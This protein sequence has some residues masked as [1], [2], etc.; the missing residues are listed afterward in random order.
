MASLKLGTSV[1]CSVPSRDSHPPS[2]L[3]EGGTWMVDGFIRP[4]VSVIVHLPCAVAIRKISWTSSFG[5]HKSLLHKIY[6]T[7]STLPCSS[8]CQNWLTW[9]R[10]GISTSKDGGVKFANMRLVKDAPLQTWGKLS[11]SEDRWE[12]K[13]AHLIYLFNFSRQLLDRVTT[14]Q[15]EICSTEASSVPC[16]SDLR[17]EASPA[18]GQENKESAK[19]LVLKSKSQGGVNATAPSFSFF[20]GEEEEQPEVHVVEDQPAFP[21]D[22]L[23]DQPPDFLDSI[24]EEVIF[25]N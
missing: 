9:R 25:F 8:I 14:L 19:Q 1:C 21:L 10:V 22:S 16:M 13:R 17:I 20:G 15:L 3:M 23:T 12:N 4:P 6:A 24:T 7:S 11:C 5:E 18:P 2:N